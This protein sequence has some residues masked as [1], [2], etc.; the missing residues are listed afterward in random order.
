MRER[1]GRNRKQR[2]GMKATIHEGAMVQQERERCLH[3]G[4]HSSAMAQMGKGWRRRRMWG[5]DA[6]TLRWW[7]GTGAIGEGGSSRW[8]NKLGCFETAEAVH[9]CGLGMVMA[10]VGGGRCDLGTGMAVIPVTENKL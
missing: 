6:A 8:A 5:G 7:C 4:S 1:D 10:L 2:E 9:R 3:G